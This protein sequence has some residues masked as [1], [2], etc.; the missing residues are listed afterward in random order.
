MDRDGSRSLDFFLRNAL[1]LI[2]MTPRLENSR[3]A[4]SLEWDQAWLASAAATFSMSRDWA[5][6][7]VSLSDGSLA[8]MATLLSFSD[9]GK[10]V[11]P[12][13]Q[14]RQY[15]GL[16]RGYEMCAAGGYGSPLSI[17]PLTD[18]HHLLILEY[19]QSLRDVAWMTS[20]IDERAS[21]YVTG[22]AK[23]N[24]THVLQ[25]NGSISDIQ[26]RWSKG[27]RAAFKQALR[28]GVSV[29]LAA[30]PEDWKAYFSIY[31]DSRRRWGVRATSNHQPALFDK[32]CNLEPTKAKL[33]LAEWEGEVVAGALCLYGNTHIAYWHGA[34]LESAFEARPVNALMAAAIEHGSSA[35]YRWF[36][37]GFS[38]GHEGVAAFKRGFGAVPVA[39]FEVRRRAATTLLAMRVLKVVA[40]G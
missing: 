5:D 23:R 32:L 12:L 10:A 24:E 11:L 40:G 15:K 4:T 7:W 25:L 21:L 20:P 36:D 37:F 1:R 27:A 34:A 35:G 8:P 14:F 22:G 38:G 6:L 2:P 17:K 26:R 31:Q 18:E 9:G 16:L 30:A 39:C 13:V 3:L 29:R 19:L 28:A 33:W